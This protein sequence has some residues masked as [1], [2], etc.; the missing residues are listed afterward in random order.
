LHMFSIF[1]DAINSRVLVADKDGIITGYPYISS[2]Y[3]LAQS[4]EARKA[5]KNETNAE[6][7]DTSDSIYECQSNAVVGGN[8]YQVGT[9]AC[10]KDNTFTFNF[11]APSTNT[12]K[13]KVV[14]TNEDGSK[15]TITPASITSLGGLTK[16]TLNTPE[17]YNASQS[18]LSVE[19]TSKISIELGDDIAGVQ[20]HDYKYDYSQ[21]GETWST[22]RVF[23]M[24]L[25]S[26]A[27]YFE[28]KYVAVMGGGHGSSKLF[29]INLE[30]DEFPGSIAGSIENKGPISI[31][32]SDSSNIAN[33]LS[34]T[35]VA[36]TPDSASGIP[37]RGAMVYVNDLEGKIT[38]INLTN[39]IKNGAEL[40][41]QTTL[42][43][44]NSS[45]DNG[46]YSYF[47]LDATIGK[48]S[49]AFWLFGGTG[50][51]Q[52]V[53]D[54]EGLTDNIL[55]GIK[56]HDYPYFKSNL[57]VPR[58]DT[59]GWKTVAVQNINLAHDVDDPSICVDT[60]LD[61]TGELCPV[62][63]DDGWV[64]H[65]DDLANNKYR[66]LT[67]TPTVFK[68]RVYFP[69][70]KP[71]DGG[72]RCSLGNAYI[73]SAD[74][75]CGTNK[76]SELPEAEGVTDDKDPCYFV[77]AGIL[78][79]LVVFGDTLYGNVAGPS[80]TEETLVSILAG[81]GEVSSYRK[82]WRQNY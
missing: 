15:T 9:N 73:C 62:A 6:A 64:I 22:P 53:N 37:W 4:K 25:S 82:S 43:K 70:Y 54:V 35:V 14:K 24:P 80:D 71:P 47:S 61:E 67:G 28:D 36:I 52:R 11:T 41:E 30:D 34:N 68:G 32:D 39:S 81:S 56:D 20:D 19:K 17:V 45:T 12:S 3:K 33:A 1:N 50:D 27:E 75:E 63:S 44:L 5:E 72:N 69:I 49:K 48:D 77:R 21:L 65:L 40:Y 29:I 31:I 23:R 76:S 42:F 58:Q 16:I 51:F 13:Y 10:Y 2:Q 78:S 79:E 18:S 59:D 57:K 46:R 7:T 8:F 26:D 74:D 55:Y 66:K 60:T 38:K